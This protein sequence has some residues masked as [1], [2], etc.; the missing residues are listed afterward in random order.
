MSIVP[1][2]EVFSLAAQMYVVW[3]HK[4]MWPVDD[5]HVRI[6]CRFRAERGI[7]DQTFEHDCAQRPPVALVAVTFLQEDLRCNIVWCSDCGVGLGTDIWVNM[8]I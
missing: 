7:A 1:S 2:N 5:L 6:V 4:I 3:E 8:L